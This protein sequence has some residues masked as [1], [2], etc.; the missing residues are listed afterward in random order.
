[1][2]T[3]QQ[4]KKG[5]AAGPGRRERRRANTREKLNR[6]AM[7][8]FAQRGFFATTTADITEAADVGQGTFFNY[9]PTKAHV[10][11]VLAEKQIEKIEAAQREAE[12]GKPPMRVVFHTLMHTIVGELTRSQALTRSLLTAF[13]SHDDVRELMWDTLQSGRERVA[14]MCAIGQERQEIR[15]DRQAADLAMTFQRGVF[16][17]L[18]LWAMQSQGDLHAWLDKALEDFWAAASPG[19]AT[20]DS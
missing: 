3:E 1:M 18:L 16:G 5:A 20:S 15:R 19:T 17:T 12:A 9:F 2:T 13:V 8:L 7:E 14:R 4:H 11:I 10:L 6:T